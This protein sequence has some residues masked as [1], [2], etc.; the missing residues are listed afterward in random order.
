MRRVNKTFRPTEELA[1]KIKERAAKEGCSESDVINAALNRYL[2]INTEN[3]F[4]TINNEI[5]NIKSQLD[6]L[7]S[8][9]NLKTS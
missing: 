5:K 2:G 4:T 9:N 1:E 3:D 6:K 7:V 8:L